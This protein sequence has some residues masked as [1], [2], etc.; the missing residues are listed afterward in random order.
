MMEN[1]LMVVASD[2]GKKHFAAGYRV[3]LIVKISTF[4]HKS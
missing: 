2:A 1:K 4:A 3:L